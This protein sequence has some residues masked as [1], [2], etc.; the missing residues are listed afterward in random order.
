MVCRMMK[1][2]VCLARNGWIFQKRCV[3]K[4]I[5]P[6]SSA[7]SLCHANCAWPMAVA[8]CADVVRSTRRAG[9]WLG[10]AHAQ[11]GFFRTSSRSATIR[12]SLFQVRRHGSQ[13]PP[14]FPDPAIRHRGREG[15]NGGARGHL[16]IWR[17]ECPGRAE[18][19][20]RGRRVG[21]AAH[22][23]WRGAGNPVGCASECPRRA[24]L[25]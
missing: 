10:A 19:G 14:K 5:K 20:A 4:L 22:T 17:S 2:H 9:R 23:G 16:R 6:R 8:P 1:L 13:H 18:V 15:K 3:K 12:P 25:R 21:T 7:A 24:N 11:Q